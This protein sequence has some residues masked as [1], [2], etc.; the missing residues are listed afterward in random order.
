MKNTSVSIFFGVFAL[1]L[2]RYGLF[3]GGAYLLL[4]ARTPAWAVA[5]RIATAPSKNHQARREVAWSLL[6]MIVFGIIGLI[7]YQLRLS[8]RIRSLQGETPLPLAALQVLTLLAFHDTYFY[9][10]HRLLHWRPLFQ[11]FHRTHHQSIDPSPLAA[12]AFHPVE[13]LFESAFLIPLLWF[14]PV[15]VGVL[16]AFQLLSFAFNVYGHLG[17]ELLPRRFASSALFG[18]FNTTSHH[19]QHH[20]RT[21]FNFG[22][23]FNLWDRLLGT[24]HPDY[25]ATFERNAERHHQP[26]DSNEKAIP[27]SR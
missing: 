2:L 22:L 4:H 12:F 3:A 24:N 23:Y 19:H 10:M 15:G 25:R 21:N 8:P 20:Q 26:A 16:F 1:Q 6:T 9:W 18:L 11:R 27:L 13:A 14:V 17:F 7:L 5:R